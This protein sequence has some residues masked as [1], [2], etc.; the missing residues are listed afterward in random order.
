MKQDRTN[1]YLP[2]GYAKRLFWYELRR[3]GKFLDLLIPRW[4]GMLS[5]GIALAMHL[6]G[7]TPSYPPC[8][9]AQAAV[10]RCNGSVVEMC[11]GEY[12]YPQYDCF[13]TT[14]PDG[15]LVPLPCVEDRGEAG[16]LDAD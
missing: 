15:E 5:A 12:W 10:Q 6:S 7:C 3:K 4:F 14:N 1:P 13:E 16:C 11:S 2:K 8:Q 9:T